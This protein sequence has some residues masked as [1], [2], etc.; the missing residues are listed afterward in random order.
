MIITRGNHWLRIRVRHLR[1]NYGNE[2]ESKGVQFH[3][4]GAPDKINRGGWYAVARDSS[5][6]SALVPQEHQIRMR[7]DEREHCTLYSLSVF[8][9]D[10]SLQLIL[11]ISSTYR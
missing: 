4:R 7:S 2:I 10:K 5:K 6:M 8:S 3:G 1:K 11:E 9:M